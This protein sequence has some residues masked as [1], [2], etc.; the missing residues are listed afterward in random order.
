M[1]L[2]NILLTLFCQIYFVFIFIDLAAIGITYVFFPEFKGLS[3]EEI[4][5]VFETPNTNP[6]ALSKKLQKAKKD[7]REHEPSSV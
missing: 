5:L 4:D 6:V 1:R 7:R 2:A 3:L